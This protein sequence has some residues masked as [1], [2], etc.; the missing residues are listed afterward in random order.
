MIFGEIAFLILFSNDQILHH[1]FN[2]L[3]FLS[4]FLNIHLLYVEVVTILLFQLILNIS[5]FRFGYLKYFFQFDFNNKLS[6]I[7]VALSLFAMIIDLIK[8]TSP[9]IIFR[10]KLS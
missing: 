10:N 2:K 5:F 6:L 9:L 1:L 8:T 3:G 7:L 4:S